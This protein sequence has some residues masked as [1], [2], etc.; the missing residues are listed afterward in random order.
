MTHRKDAGQDAI[1]DFAELSELA[2]CTQHAE[3]SQNS[4][5][6]DPMRG[7]RFEQHARKSN[8]DNYHIKNLPTVCEE[9]PE[10]IKSQILL[11]TIKTYLLIWKI[12][13]K[14]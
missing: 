6:F 3:D 9:I 14:N 7:C 5:L 10:P 4:Q 1:D 11:T 8:H 12:K 13:M 2:D